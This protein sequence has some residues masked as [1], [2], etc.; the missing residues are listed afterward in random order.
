MRAHPDAV[1][2]QSA[3]RDRLPELA[4]DAP[5]GLPRRAPPR[6]SPVSPADDLDISPPMGPDDPLAVL[7]DAALNAEALDPETRAALLALLA[8]MDDLRSEADRLR[9]EVRDLSRLA[10]LDPLADVFNRRAFVREFSRV[11]SLADRYGLQAGLVYVDLDDFKSI[12]DRFGHQVGDDVIRHVA[13]V[14][15]SHVR[16]SDVVGR[17]GGDEFAVGLAAGGLDTAAMKA[18]HFEEYLRATPLVSGAAELMVRASV[19]VVELRSGETAE[20][21]IARADAAMYARKAAARS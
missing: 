19:G 2:S 6:R 8:Q 4:R 11:M 17:M 15:K 16:E 9:D 5:S 1:A 18:A 12:N 20:E 3:T 14:L 13:S 21:A 7:D 10:D